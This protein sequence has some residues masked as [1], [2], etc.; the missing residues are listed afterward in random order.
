[1]DIPSESK[2]ISSLAKTL[3]QAKFLPVVSFHAK[4]EESDASRVQ[5]LL[6][7][8]VSRV[9]DEKV[10]NLLNKFM[11]LIDPI[12]KV[13]SQILPHVI[14]AYDTTLKFY[15]SL[16]LDIIY[17]L[18]GL[19]LVFFG[20]TY[21]L[22]IAALETFYMT[23]YPQ[24]REGVLYL[25]EE[26]R[27]IFEASKKDDKLDENNDGIADVK[28]ITVK[29]LAHR[30]IALFFTSCNN[31]NKCFTMLNQ[32]ITSLISVVAVLKVQFAKV[33][34]L[35]NMIG[36]S[37]RRPIEYV[38]VPTLGRLVPVKYQKWISPIIGLICKMVAISIA[39]LIQRIISSVQSA[40]RGGLIFAR[41]ILKLAKEK[42]Y[43]PSYDED[44]YY[45]EALGWTVAAVGI[46][47]QFFFGFGLPFPLNF[48][49]F[50]LTL[51]ENYLVWMVSE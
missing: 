39:W 44:K 2:P 3:G 27:I 11:P 48:L 7:Q 19:T 33:I 6:V 18:L 25:Q 16:P 20:G 50:P 8:N 31:P 5:S 17:A 42:G 12:L 37:M 10:E 41:R 45:D 47:F 4:Q 32:I 15:N 28:Q 35:G 23:G 14:H 34:A 51:F 26:M 40:I 46:L 21:C 38:F 9:G 30:K 13:F 22:M 24:V 43:F 49:L 36:E 29:E 1:M